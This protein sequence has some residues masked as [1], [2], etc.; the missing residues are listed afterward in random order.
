MNK[1]WSG[2]RMN[3]EG[4]PDFECQHFLSLLQKYNMNLYI[5]EIFWRQKSRMTWL[6]VGDVDTNFFINLQPY[7]E[8]II[9][10]I[11]LK[12]KKDMWLRM[13]KIK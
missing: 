9:I 10:L 12:T 4:L 6:K 2:K 8:E 5:Q 11:Y 13:K 7:V 3:Q 1:Y